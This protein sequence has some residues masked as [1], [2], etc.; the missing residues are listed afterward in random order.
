MSLY[1]VPSWATV[2]SFDKPLTAKKFQML[3]LLVAIQQHPK[4]DPLN[5]LRR[6]LSY[7][8]AWWWKGSTA[9]LAEMFEFGRVGYDVC[10]EEGLIFDVM[11]FIGKADVDEAVSAWDAN[12]FINWAFGA[13][14][15]WE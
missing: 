12:N 13:Y 9:D 10:D 11:D 1:N 15:T 7:Y 8:R 4:I 6:L 2:P 5:A 3:V 14:L